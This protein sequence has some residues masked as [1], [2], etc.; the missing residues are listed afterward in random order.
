MPRYGLDFASPPAHQQKHKREKE[1]EGTIVKMYFL[2]AGVVAALLGCPLA[3]H[4]QG[5][6]DGASHGA[7][8][9]GQAAGPIGG[10]VG[11][12]VGGVIGGVDGVLGVRPASYPQEEA[13]PPVRPRHYG[14][15]HSRRRMRHMRHRHAAS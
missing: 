9:G 13:A 11:G 3:A 6:P 1:R 2:Y 7:Y 14:H 15:R 10:V 12:V 5:I 8:V 4:A